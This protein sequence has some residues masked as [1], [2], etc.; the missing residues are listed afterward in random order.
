MTLHIFKSKSSLEGSIATSKDLQHRR[1]YCEHFAVLIERAREGDGQAR[2]R[3]IGLADCL[4]DVDASALPVGE[5]V[6]AEQLIAITLA[7]L[8]LIPNPPPN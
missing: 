1:Q 3:L 2:I 7:Q 5:Q 8:L 4:A 6:E